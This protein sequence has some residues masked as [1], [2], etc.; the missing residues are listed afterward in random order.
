MKHLPLIA[1]CALAGSALAL[2]ARAQEPPGSA[3]PREAAASSLPRSGSLA[4]AVEAAWQRAVA[5]REASGLRRRAEAERTAASALWAGSPSLELDHRTDRWQDNEDR[6]ESAVALAWPLWLPGQRAARG[7]AAQ[8]G[9]AFAESSEALSRLRIAGD[10]REAAW[11]LI[12]QQREL[13]Q[14]DAA[15]DSLRLLA[16]DVDR[17]VKAGDLARADALAARAELL[18]ATALQAEARQRLFAAESRWTTLTG[19]GPLASAEEP[20]PPAGTDPAMAHP[21]IR[22]AMQATEHAQRKVE[23]ARASRLDPP[24]LSIGYRKDEPGRGLPS[25][26]SVTI[27][28]RVPFG[29]DDRNLPLQAAA[30]AELDVARTHEERLRERLVAEA[31]AA[32]S[33]VESAQRQLDLE[34]ERAAMLRERASLIDKSFRAGESALP[35]L[36]RALAAATQAQ[37]ALSRQSAALGLARAR[38]NQSLGVFP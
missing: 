34:K 12:A 1:A 13:L 30:L 26:G 32:R 21:E 4:G 8:A 27:G 14:A 3:A 20:A 5:A 6:R 37:A 22:A 7:S 38:L 11:S 33:A 36:L 31:S 29:T 24:E 23:L 16:E 10:V 9:V 18:G 19:T 25:Q 17:R 15:A 35:D 2:V 28:L